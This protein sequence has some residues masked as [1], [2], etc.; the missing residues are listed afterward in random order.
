MRVFPLNCGQIP[1]FIRPATWLL[2]SYPIEPSR[3]RTPVMPI[4][5]GRACGPAC[6]DPLDDAADDRDETLSFRNALRSD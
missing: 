6:E 1:S 4:E 2:G 5:P 3:L